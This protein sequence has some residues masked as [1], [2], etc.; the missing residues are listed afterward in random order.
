MTH[1]IG[2][3]GKKRSGKTE[4]RNYL[5]SHYGYRSINFADPLKHMLR[6]MGLSYEELWGSKKEIKS[7]LLGGKTP[8]H[9]MQTLGTE[10]GRNL[11][12]DDLWTR[13]WRY[14]ITN[15]EDLRVVTDDVRF[16]NEAILIG[17]LGGTII[18]IVRPRLQSED[19]HQSEKEM[20]NITPVFTIVNDGSIFMLKASV[21]KVMEKIN[22]M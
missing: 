7:D 12:S 20:D 11:I 10:W 15:L 9:A 1:I 18:E 22:A 4:V 14:K 17:S 21:Q 3:T 13:A 19:S 5:T 6:S 16:L 2:I 8:R